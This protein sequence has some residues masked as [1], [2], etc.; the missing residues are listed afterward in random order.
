MAWGGKVEGRSRIFCDAQKVKRSSKNEQNMF[1]EQ[2][3]NLEGDIKIRD[4]WSS[5]VN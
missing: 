5:K 2:R 4:K 1:I 3:N